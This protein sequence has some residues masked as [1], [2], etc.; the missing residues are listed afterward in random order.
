MKLLEIFR[1]FDVICKGSS[2]HSRYQVTYI[3]TPKANPKTVTIEDLAKHIE[4][5]QRRFPDRNFYMKTTKI[6]GRTFH[7]IT[8]KT[9]VMQPD[10]TKKRV[11][12]RVPIYMDIENQKFY[13]P[14]SY[15]KKQ[16]RLTCY[17]I[18]RT[19]GTLG[20]STTK[21]GGLRRRKM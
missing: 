5:L 3:I 17:I 21:Y 2:F 6:N 1:D 20:V 10:G 13:V 16:Y 14:E 9:Y 15:V 12:D 11:Y 8:R 18:M 4:D 7:V 19:L